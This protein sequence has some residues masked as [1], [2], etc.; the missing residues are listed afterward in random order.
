MCFI[1]CC[2]TLSAPVTNLELGRPQESIAY[3]KQLAIKYPYFADG[4]AA[5][6]VMLWGDGETDNVMDMWETAIEQDS[7]YRDLEW[8]R[9]IRRWP[10]SLVKT[11]E[12]FKNSDIYKTAVE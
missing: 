2:F 1:T 7:R 12:K 4:Q 6:A 3:F 10:P 9:D 8:V 5:L 11:L